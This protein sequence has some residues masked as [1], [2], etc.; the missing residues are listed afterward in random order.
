MQYT[1][2]YDEKLPYSSS[3]GLAPGMGGWVPGSSASGAAFVS[4]SAPCLVD[5]GA[6]YPYVKNT[7]VF[8]CPSDSNAPKTLLSYSMNENCSAKSLAAATQSS[9]TILLV[10][11]GTSPNNASNSL[12]DG[13]FRPGSDSPSNIHL[14][15][16]NLAFLDG[17]VKWRRPDQIKM[18]DYDF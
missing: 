3:T 6:L 17:H 7:Q 5:Q 14:E 2:D 8:V 10:D 16:P 13:N 15:G 9:I 12:N 18:T 11:E 1:Q 4:T